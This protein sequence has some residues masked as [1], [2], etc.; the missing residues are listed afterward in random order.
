MLKLSDFGL[1]TVFRHKGKERLLERRCG[2]LPYIAPEVLTKSRYHAEP[3]DVWSCGM[4]LLAMLVGGEKFR[5]L[6]SLRLF[7]RL[8]QKNL[9][10]V[11]QIRSIDGRRNT[12]VAFWNLIASTIARSEP[13]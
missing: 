3:A 12:L 10:I 11:T 4:V 6:Y 13:F 5:L 8:G 1:A 9:G 2:T 7:S